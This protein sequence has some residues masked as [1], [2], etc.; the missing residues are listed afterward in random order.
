MRKGFIPVGA[1]CQGTN[2][3]MARAF[4]SFLLL[5]DYAYCH[6][7]GIFYAVLHCLDV[8]MRRLDSSLRSHR[9]WWSHCQHACS[10]LNKTLFASAGPNSHGRGHRRSTTFAA[11]DR[12][13]AEED[14]IS[15]G[16]KKLS[17]GHRLDGT[18]VPKSVTEPVDATSIPPHI[19]CVRSC[20]LLLFSFF[21]SCLVGIFKMIRRFAALIKSTISHHGIDYTQQS[22]SHGD[23][24]LGL[25]DSFDQSLPDRFLAGIG[26]AECNPGLAQSPSERSRAGLG[27]LSGLSSSGGLLVVGSKAGPELQG[28][29]V[30]ESVKRSDFGSD[31]AGPYL[32]DSGNTFKHGCPG[33]EFITSI[34]ED[35]FSSETFALPFDKR[36]DI[37]EVCE[38]LPLDIFEQVSVGEE[39]LLSGGSIEFGSA[40][41]CGMEYG[42]H[43]VFG[44]AESLAQ[45]PPVSAKLPQVHQGLVGDKPEW[46]ISPDQ[47]DRN[48]TYSVWLC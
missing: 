19:V 21:Q 6:I 27:D 47:P 17:R 40:N 29:G 10:G 7:C 2:F 28:I 36:N 43:T 18:S 11:A 30:G 3:A 31:N 16:R 46:A 38:G 5:M 33:G 8:A 48:I 14:N 39:P 23:I 45:L 20:N 12:L 34:G 35:D 44:S 15:P 32:S 1:V 26:S 9:A 41:I 42:F 4:C 25:S 24:G 37:N 13:R 22:S